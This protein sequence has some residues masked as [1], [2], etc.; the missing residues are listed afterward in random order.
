MTKQAFDI[1]GPSKPGKK[2][3]PLENKAYTERAS[4]ASKKPQAPD[5]KPHFSV[6][7]ATT[8]RKSRRKMLYSAGAMFCLVVGFVGAAMFREGLSQGL[9]RSERDSQTLQSQ[10]VADTEEPAAVEVVTPDEVSTRM[11]F[12]G[13]V[14]WGRAIQTAA[15]RS[16]QGP[17][18]L[19]SG[20]SVE[21]KTKYDMWV[22]DMECPITDHDI[23]YQTQV[24]SLIFNCIPEYVSEA[25]KWFD[26]L[27]LANNHTDNNGGEWGLEQTRVNLEA[28]GIQHFGTYSTDE[29]DDTCEIISAS[30]QSKLR[31]GVNIPVALCGFS[32]VVN[33][34]PS[35]DQLAR[36]SELS[37][38][39]PVIA[40]P[41]MGVEYRPIAEAEK[42]TAYRSMID[43]G[44]DIVVGAH[45]H[46]VQ[47]SEVY[48]G[49]LIAY[50]VGNFLFDQQTLGA[51]TTQTL[52]VGLEMKISDQNTIAFYTNIGSMCSAYKD[53]CLALLKEA[54]VSRPDISVSYEFE[55]FDESS[56]VPVRASDEV[57]ERIQNA[58]TINSLSG[59][60]KIWEK[61]L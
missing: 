15:E 53:N 36:M 3:T 14:F 34:Q 7:T 31:G 5:L 1:I 23:P 33:R 35:E 22:G 61:K 49:R 54:A 60:N 58:A 47:N 10:L 51:E 25:A 42:E 26:A 29:P 52:G 57:R 11:M 21:D 40:L 43:H 50:S 6:D 44:A 45:P 20:L 39:V 38:Y 41:H 17:A 9:F 30:A 13:D 4:Q 55:Y 18:Y 28:A 32:L 19:F 8:L 12:V 24:S 56:G 2:N 16:G 37:K 46:V 48:H 59:L 27:S